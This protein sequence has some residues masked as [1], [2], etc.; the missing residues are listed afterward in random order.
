MRI[1][2]IGM[3]GSGKSYW[4]KALSAQLGYARLDLDHY[5]E[6]KEGKSI[7]EL[8]AISESY[9]RNAESLALKSISDDFSENIIVATGGGAPLYYDNMEWMQ[10]NGMVVYL[11]ASVDYLFGRLKHAYTERP[12]LKSSTEKEL[13]EKAAILFEERKEIY[14]QA[15]YIIDVERATLDT[16]AKTLKL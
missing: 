16:F 9:F 3:P 12:L 6:T 13:Y 8:F 4:S 7:P 5:I 11:K 1:F 2:F 14:L 15:P 10:E